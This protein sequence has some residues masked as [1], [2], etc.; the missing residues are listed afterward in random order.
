MKVIDEVLQSQSIDFVWSTIDEY[1]ARA[2]IAGG[3]IQPSALGE[4]FDYQAILNLLGDIKALMPEVELMTPDIIA[5]IA[6][7]ILDCKF[8]FNRR[9]FRTAITIFYTDMYGRKWE[10]NSLRASF[11]ADVFM[12][13]HNI[14][15]EEE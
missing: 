13:E 9:S 8:G 10:A 2:G 11:A 15:I 5:L 7:R 12:T 14:F 6:K 1:L 3:N 4:I